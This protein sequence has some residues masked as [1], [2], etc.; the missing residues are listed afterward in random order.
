MAS[1]TAASSTT[2]IDTSAIEPTKLPPSRWKP[3]HPLA[4]VQMSEDEKLSRRKADLDNQAK[5]YGLTPWEYPALV[6]WIVPEQIA[7]VMV[8]CLK[9]RG[10]IVEGSAD[11]RGYSGQTGSQDEAFGRAEVECSA[12][13]SVDPR[14][15]GEP[16][17]DQ[18]SLIY[19]YWVEFLVPCLKKHGINPTI[20]S[21]EVFVS[22]PTPMAEYPHDDEKVVKEC[23]YG[24]PSQALLGEL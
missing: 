19:D 4:P 16:S 5:S 24:A 11:G 7:S 21:R 9:Q 17:Q 6:R 15:M 2:I 14:L 3:K 12:M 20:P 10:F 22:T 1:P 13:Y 18:K 8:P 23:P